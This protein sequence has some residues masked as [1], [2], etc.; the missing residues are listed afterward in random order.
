MDSDFN[1]R[2]VVERFVTMQAVD[3]RCG[4]SATLPMQTAASLL[5][6]HRVDM[7]RF[8]FV[9]CATRLHVPIL[10]RF[11]SGGLGSATLAL[12]PNSVLKLHKTFCGP[13]F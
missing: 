5:S 7:L 3:A 12:G 10:R 1:E 6:Y 9:V 4:V 13:C 11:N 8:R 2:G